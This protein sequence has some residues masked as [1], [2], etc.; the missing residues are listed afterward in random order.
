MGLK[1]FEELPSSKSHTYANSSSLGSVDP[2]PSNWT[3]SP[4][5]ALM[6][7]PA[8]AS[9][10]SFGSVMMFSSP[11]VIVVLHT[12]EEPSKFRELS[13]GALSSKDVSDF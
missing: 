4:G 10:G 5:S 7:G 3:V 1:P 2:E 9:G 8:L 11:G 12:H 6:S 13:S